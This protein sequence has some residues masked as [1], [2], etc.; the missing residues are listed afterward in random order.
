MASVK[1]LVVFTVAVLHFV[2]VSGR[3]RA[4]LLMPY[5][6]LGQCSFKKCKRLVA[7]VTHPVGKLKTIICLDTLDRIEKLFYKVLEKLCGRVSAVLLKSLQIAETAV[8]LQESI[9]T[10]LCAIFLSNDTGLRDEF[11]VDLHTLAGVLH[12]FVWF[13]DILWGWCR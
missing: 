10:P 4:D 8:F 13:W 3:E 12:L 11:D 1:I 6:E 5:P 9:L 7:A 2:I